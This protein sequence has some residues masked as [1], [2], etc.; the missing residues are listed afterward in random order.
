MKFNK[1]WDYES[2]YNY[3]YTFVAKIAMWLLL[4]MCLIDLAGAQTVTKQVILT[5][6]DTQI[7]IQTP[8]Q[9][10][11]TT[12]GQLLYKTFDIPFE[13]EQSVYYNTTIN[14]TI[15]LNQTNCSMVYNVTYSSEYQ[16]LLTRLNHTMEM[17]NAANA[18]C[19]IMQSTNL[20][21]TVN[22]SAE[23]LMDNISRTN[24]QMMDFLALKILPEKDALRACEFDMERAKGA[25]NVSTIENG[26]LRRE[27]T[28]YMVLCIIELICIFTLM[29]FMLG[30]NF[31]KKQTM[32]PTSM[33]PPGGQQ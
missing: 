32:G 14:N 22:I 1:N 24:Q 6:N 20:N 5:V 4:L 29:T 30:R 2:D 17:C 9:V 8:D 31:L 10:Y 12:S 3:V 21:M 11:E 25:L 15:M 13:Y 23:S 7:R 33:T 19:S 18:T 28:L 27:N 16:T 26:S